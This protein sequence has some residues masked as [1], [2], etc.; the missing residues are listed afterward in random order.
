MDS[1]CYELTTEKKN[2]L[3]GI[4]F[5]IACLVSHS[6]LACAALCDVSDVYTAYFKPVSK[7]IQMNNRYE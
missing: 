5:L 2:I 3:E 6:C 1:V 4:K 7:R